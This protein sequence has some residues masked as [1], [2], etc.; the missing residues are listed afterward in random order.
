MGG[1]EVKKNK[2]LLPNGKKDRHRNRVPQ[3]ADAADSTSSDQPLGPAHEGSRALKR[4]RQESGY[5]ASSS[6]PSSAPISVPPSFPR[7]NV[8][9]FNR[10][11]KSATENRSSNKSFDAVQS[12]GKILLDKKQIHDNI[13]D[14][15]GSAPARL[16]KWARKPEERS[17]AAPEETSRSTSAERPSSTVLSKMADRVQAVALNKEIA[18]NANRKDLTTATAAFNKAVQNGWANSH[19]YAAMLNAHVRCGDI[20]GA[21]VVFQS[22]RSHPRLRMDVISCTTMMKGYCASGRMD[23]CVALLRDMQVHKPAIQPNIRTI[24]TILRGCLSNGLVRECDRT[25]NMIK[26]NFNLQPDASS[27]EYEALMLCEGLQ[28]DKLYPMIGRLKSENV[29]PNSS[30]MTIYT[31][32]AKAL[33]VIHDWSNCRKYIAAAREAIQADANSAHESSFRADD[34]LVDVSDSE[35]E[36]DNQFTRGKIT[37]VQKLP[38]AHEGGTVTAGRTSVKTSKQAVSGGKR[39]WREVDVAR[40]QSLE[41]YQQHKRS[42]L[43]HDLSLLEAYMNTQQTSKAKADVDAGTEANMLPELPYFQKTISFTNI[44]GASRPPLLRNIIEK[45]GL[46][47]YLQKKL[48]ESAANSRIVRELVSS[49]GDEVKSNSKK[50]KSGQTTCNSGP[51]ASKIDAV[52]TKVQGDLDNIFDGNVINFNRLFS[53]RD[54]Q[55]KHIPVKLEICSGTGEWVA[56]QALADFG[57]ANWVALEVKH[58]RVY[59]TFLRMAFQNVRNLCS[60]HGDATAILPNHF[61]PGSVHSI[62]INH[63][64]PPV[65]FG[66]WGSKSEGA[67]EGET[68]NQEESASKGVPKKSGGDW[69]QG[70]HLLSL[71]FFAQLERVLIAGGTITVVTDNLWYGKMLLRS[72]ASAPHPRLLS[73]VD[74]ESNPLMSDDASSVNPL[75]VHDE[76]SGYKL[77]RGRP[78]PRV[79]HVAAD[80]SSYFDR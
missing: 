78:G 8:P 26:K 35:D 49:F 11:Q 59:Q 48:N 53:E 41:V 47:Y 23:K 20:D 17:L 7:N 27:W 66:G 3:P 43:L 19:T 80:A 37:M 69:S 63:P 18:F 73:P 28:F 34:P 14:S 62:F 30:M 58:D 61:S 38:L 40:D 76:I 72:V 44:E 55:S 25:F 52:L 10:A 74:V 57:K 64:E 5:A 46:D 65:Q 45:L 32:L 31:A 75:S 51:V 56:Q 36:G 79:G 68:N 60:I 29:L 67:A 1:T 50:P 42:E 22:L 77:Y 71:E 39:A 13:G 70:K 16:E 9:G 2:K 12:Q 33:A 4:S 54:S 24:N 21:E 6:A 15:N